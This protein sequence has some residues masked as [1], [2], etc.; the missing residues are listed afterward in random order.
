MEELAGWF[1]MIM[2]AIAAIGFAL[3][4]VAAA[5]ARV[6]AWVLVFW[7][8][9]F[10][11]GIAIGAL[12]GVVLP[13]RVLR[14]KAAEEPE[15]ATPEAVVAGKVLGDAPKGQAKHFGWDRAWPIYNPHQAKRDANAVLTQRKRTVNGAFS[16]LFDQDPKPAWLAVLLPPFAGFAIGAWISTSVWYVVMRLLGGF[17]YIIQQG[18]VLTYRS[19]D[20][21]IRR[22]R[23]ATLRCAKCYRVT[24]SPSYRCIGASCST[25]HHD[26]RP[27]PLGIIR[28]RCGCGTSIPATV[29]GAAKHLDTVCPFCLQDV[30]KGSGTRRVL[31][32]PVIGAVGAGKTQF[33]SSGVVE[34][35][36]RIEALSGSLAPIS[37]VAETFLKAAATAVTSGQRVAKTAW[38]D[39]P[40]GVPLILSLKGR[41]LE[42][43]LM[44]AAGENFVDW[45]RSQG[46]GYIDTADVLLFMLDP[47]ALPQVTEQLRVANMG[48]VVP[49]AQGD[50]EDSYASVVD[51]LRAEDVRLGSKS[52]AIVLTKLDVLQRLPGLGSLDPSDS[53]TIKS[54]L[55]RS[56]ADGFIRRVDQDFK[57]VEYFAVDSYGTRDGHN[58]LHP[59]RVL[60]WALKTT[61]SRLSVIPRAAPV[62][63]AE[64]AA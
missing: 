15:I 22:R 3:W 30:P 21:L 41:E 32:V 54:W 5:L 35:Q 44:D 24:T 56:G 60:D 16:W 14:G 1:L 10:A 20:R 11:A 48:G 7:I 2:A 29:G 46:L 52:L 57:R 37:P 36:S 13:A 47:L 25:I 23:K 63:V 59:V 64:G 55:R 39:R 26:V 53:A 18:G 17:V 42:I 12:A 19:Y 62:P 45:E 43:Q 51:R 49:I 40:E 58:P 27:G 4:V 28:R 61:D 8:A 34:L 9:A 31:P 50:P 38:E 6:F 33:L